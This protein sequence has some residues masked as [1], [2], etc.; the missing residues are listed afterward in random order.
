MTWKLNLGSQV[1][2]TGGVKFRVWASAP[3]KVEVVIFD[4]GG[5]ELGSQALEPTEQHYFEGFVPNARPGLRYSYRLDGSKLRPDPV[6]GYLP[7]GVHGKTEI[8]A[9]DF[10]WTDQNWPG[11]PAE[12]AVI[13]ELHVGT[14]TP[15][16][17]FRALI[18]KLP[19]FKD[20]G[21][22]VLE[23]M[24]LADFPGCRNWGYDG[25]SLY[26][27]AACYGRP[28]D[29][30]A[31]VNAAHQNGLAVIL[32]VVYNHFGP[33]GNY[34]R[35]FSP[36]YFTD[37]Y[38]T[39]WG[40]GVNFECRE[41]REFFIDNALYWLSEYHFDGL[42]LDATHAIRDTTNPHFLAELVLRAKANLLERANLL[43]YAEDERNNPE[44]I[45]E[46]H[47]TGYG[48]SG[49]WADDFHHVVRVALTGEQEAYYQD[50]TGTSA[51]LA[52]ILNNGWLYEGQLSK[53]SRHE[54]GTPAGNFPPDRYLH[55]IQNHDQIG[56]RALGDRLN[57]V[58]TP[59]AYRAVS[60]LLL[61][62]PYTPLLFQGQEWAA[63]TPWQFFTD[64]N[65]ELGKLITAGRRKEFA[66]FAGF[67]HQEVPDPQLAATFER[68]KLDWNEL[69]IARH[70]QIL[71]LYRQLLNWRQQ[72]YATGRPQRGNWLAAPLDE[73]SLALRLQSPAT[74][75]HYLLVVNLNE[76]ASYNLTQ[77]K[78]M[79]WQPGRAKV[80]LGSEQTEFGGTNSIRL[81]EAADVLSF[82][83]PG[84]ILLE[85]S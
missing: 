77:I 35:D 41:A 57:H 74:G 84:A 15:E 34:L 38:H 54:R 76:Q 7:E 36:E 6:S 70:A 67:N 32:D 25:V 4:E 24:P 37:D 11:V 45:E 55:C 52:S 73:K 1:Q 2:E 26:A 81:D 17:T 9:P 8:V 19:Y 58:I 28:A 79:S 33:D 39:P 20:L 42:R 44:L 40:Q 5:R 22:T 48:L 49:V 83:T 21:V 80:L 61:L 68:S 46:H 3:T 50:Y 14:A 27:P 23:L 72:L 62:S 51:E 66:G 16:G 13:Y 18:E 30:K 71:A 59:A 12:Q 47:E 29:L 75:K 56:N 43:I 60:T 53:F 64:H 31:L 69:Q 63:G 78:E 65:A 85:I 10:D 82:A